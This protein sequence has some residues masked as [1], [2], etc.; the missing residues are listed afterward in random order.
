MEAYAYADS[1]FAPSSTNKTTANAS[2]EKM[3]FSGQSVLMDSRITLIYKMTVLDTTLDMSK[4]TFKIS[5]TD[6]EGNPQVKNYTIDDAIKTAAG[7]EMNF[8]EFHATQ[9]NAQALLTVYIDGVE[10][11]SYGNSVENYCYVTNKNSSGNN[12]AEMIALAKRILLYG[13]AC[14]A[15]YGK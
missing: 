11:C 8:A 7:Y 1:Q 15:T 14:A 9:L 2:G 12:S 4:V 6:A 13:E 5:Y 3:K 10:H